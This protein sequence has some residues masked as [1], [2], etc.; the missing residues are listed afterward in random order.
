[1]QQNAK[2]AIAAHLHVLLRR[3]TGR[4]TDI[5]W[6]AENEEYATAIIRFSRTQARET[7]ARELAE[8]AGKLEQAMRKIE[9]P[10]PAHAGVRSTVFAE[11]RAM[12]PA[13][14]PRLP[15]A[16]KDHAYVGGIR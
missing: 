3:K 1:M 8:W 5:E 10:P 4:V 15:A 12:H 16:D 14:E 13:S 9:A 11:P 2:I 6:L 7:G